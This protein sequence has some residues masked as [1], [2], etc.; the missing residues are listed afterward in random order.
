[1]LQEGKSR[2]WTKSTCQTFYRGYGVEITP[3]MICGGY[4]TG[5]IDSCGVSSQNKV[6][7]DLNKGLCSSYVDFLTACSGT[8]I[9]VLVIHIYVI[10]YVV[11]AY[12]TSVLPLLYAHICCCGNIP[13][14]CCL[15]YARTCYCC[16]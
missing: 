4:N 9:F 8:C 3:D 2:V 6:N 13:Y 10:L 7:I 14:Y 16:I 11:L 12:A 15:L 5:A 1:M